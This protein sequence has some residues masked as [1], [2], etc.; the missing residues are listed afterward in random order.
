MSPNCNSLHEHEV[1][2][3]SLIDWRMIF[4]SGLWIS[5]LA[6]ILT[7][8]GFA[9]YHAA[10]ASRRLGDLAGRPRYRAAIYAGL[11]LICFGLLGSSDGFGKNLV[12]ALL[13]TG[14]LA[15]AVTALRAAHR[16]EES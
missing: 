4:F 16:S 9:D 2:M 6:M 3:L 13:G 8:L 15:Y 11:T 1:E 14:F 12:W 7:A 5:G 10:I